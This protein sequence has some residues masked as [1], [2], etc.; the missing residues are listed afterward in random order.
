MD[1]FTLEDDGLFTPAKIIVYSF[2]LVIIILF[3][4]SI[5]N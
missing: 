5:E 3:G 1:K 4:K 2:I